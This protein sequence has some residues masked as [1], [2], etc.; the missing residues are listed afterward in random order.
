MPTLD[1]VRVFTGEDGRGGN[2]LGVFLDGPA[3]AAERRQAVAARLGFAE[4]VFV[5]DAARG[6]VRIFTPGVELPFAGH[7]LVGTAWLLRRRGA[8]VDVLRPPVGDVAVRA[9]DDRA[10]IRG[11]GEWN[12]IE[13]VQL[14]SATDVDALDGSP[15][16]GDDISAWAWIDEP[17]GEVRA[18]VFPGQMGIEED[19]ATGMAAVGMAC[20]LG[21]DLRIHQGVGS[22][23]LARSLGD[24]WA[25][26]GGRV[27]MVETRE[28]AGA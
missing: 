11:R 19:E 2:L 28:D 27:A 18:R 16:G 15:R 24:G 13:I 26:V 1:V 23:L 9:A 4:T 10:F 17:R 12:N 14:P 21:R 20:M 22:L 5:D 7:P 25:E 6:V 8:A 3:V